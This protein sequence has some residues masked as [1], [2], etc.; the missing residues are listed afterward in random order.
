MFN[1]MFNKMKEKYTLIEKIFEEESLKELGSKGLKVRALSLVKRLGV[2]TAE[3]LAENHTIMELSLYK[4]SGEKTIEYLTTCLTKAG[5]RLGY[6]RPYSI[7]FGL[8]GEKNVEQTVFEVLKNYDSD[9]YHNADSIIKDARKLIKNSRNYTDEEDINKALSPENIKIILESGSLKEMVQSRLGTIESSKET[10][11]NQ[12]DI[13]YYRLDPDK[14]YIE[15]SINKDLLN[16]PVTDLDLSIRTQDCLER[17]NI[18]TIEDLINVSPAFLLSLRGFGKTSLREI[19][20][21][22]GDSGL[23]LSEPKI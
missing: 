4:N 12:N 16:K 22:L 5:L 9:S 1:R 2:N 7:R 6:S 10:P 18:N 17:Q 3:D 15:K 11:E 21:K 13:L 14:N 20:R 8:F 23:S 19:D